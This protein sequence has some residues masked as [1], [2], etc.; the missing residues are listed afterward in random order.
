MRNNGRRALS[1]PLLGSLVL[2][3]MGAVS[4]DTNNDHDSYLR[5]GRG[6]VLMDY[7]DRFDLA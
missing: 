3:L 1:L 7:I 4:P 5:R 2:L 6:G